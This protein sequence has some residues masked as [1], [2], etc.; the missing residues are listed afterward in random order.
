[1]PSTNL[2]GYIHSPL[3]NNELRDSIAFD[4]NNQINQKFHCFQNTSTSNQINVF[5]YQQASN[6]T[7]QV[8]NVPLPKDHLFN[9]PKGSNFDQIQTRSIDASPIISVQNSNQFDNNKIINYNSQFQSIPNQDK[10][11]EV[12]RTSILNDQSNH[13]N[14]K[15]DFTQYQFN[16]SPSLKLG[17]RKYIEEIPI[18]ITPPP[19]IEMKREIIPKEIHLERPSYVDYIDEFNDEEIVVQKSPF[20]KMVHECV[21]KCIEIPLPPFQ[22]K[23]TRKIEKSVLIPTPPVEEYIPLEQIQEVVVPSQSKKGVKQKI[24][25]EE[26]I[27][28]P[29]PP[30]IVSTN[31]IVPREVYIEKPSV[32]QN[33]EEYEDKEVLYPQP[34][35]KT[36]FQ[37]T[38]EK[39]IEIPVPPH[40]EYRKKI[41]QKKIIIPSQPI[42]TLV[43]HE[44]IQEVVI[45][46]PTR[47]GVKRKIIYEEPKLVPQESKREIQEEVYERE[48]YSN[49]KPEVK[50]IPEEVIKE[51]EIPNPPLQSLTLDAIDNE[52]LVPS[53]PKKAILNEVFSKTVP[54]A[55][56]SYKAIREDIIEQN[57]LVPSPSKKGISRRVIVDEPAQVPIPP[58]NVITENLVTREIHFIPKQ[59]N[60]ILEE[61]I[62]K[63]L[64][65]FKPAINAKLVEKYERKASIQPPFFSEGIPTELLR[66]AQVDNPHSFIPLPSSSE[67]LRK[68]NYLPLIEDPSKRI[69]D[70][71][72]SINFPSNFIS[73]IQGPQANEIYNNPLYIN[74]FR[75]KN[76]KKDKFSYLINSRGDFRE[77]RIPFQLNRFNTS[78]TNGFY[79]NYYFNQ[80][81]L[82]KANQS[83]N[84]KPYYNENDMESINARNHS[85]NYSLIPQFTLQKKEELN[86]QNL[87]SKNKL[88]KNENV[89]E[90][91]NE[92]G[93]NSFRGSPE[94][95]NYKDNCYSQV[96]KGKHFKDNEVINVFSNLQKEAAKV[97][98]SEAIPESNLL[99]Q[100]DKRTA[101]MNKFT[102]FN[103]DSRI[104]KYSKINV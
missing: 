20:T 58:K 103:T 28:I 100:K 87:Q 41:N 19:K 72:K 66:N 60:K 45:P 25:L 49:Q 85:E 27:L 95:M 37:E 36:I 102:Q 75:V 21:E 22:G 46:S 94:L 31:E 18:E 92:K 54:I 39:E 80:P 43:P 73:D 62:D 51:I 70:N 69:V 38:V 101:G 47:K 81:Q 4:Y 96:I 86:Y 29:S 12:K 14:L 65:I 98:E 90:I 99:F 78:Y 10:T 56:P 5:P 9:N 15:E 93:E 30:K 3:V 53:T 52:I 44:I 42:E 57:H 35:I 79:D 13:Q 23:N 24:I 76:N 8:I 55:K 84:M 83:L 48:V 97:I 68:H 104:I 2:H 64:I 74:D 26:P 82:R 7:S 17:S 40:R 11:N 16:G 32:I 67:S 6:I 50:Y 1:M 33:V 91:N 88:Q 61:V 63:E 89:G 71:S 77:E 59:E 34:Q